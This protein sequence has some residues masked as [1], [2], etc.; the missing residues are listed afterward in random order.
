MIIPKK[1]NIMGFPHQVK[2]V[3][4]PP[5]DDKGEE[6]NGIIDIDTGII[7]LDKNLP[8]DKLGQCFLHE[9]LHA[10]DA[11]DELSEVATESFARNLYQ[12][13]KENGILR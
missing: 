2:L 13:L 11:R 3:S 4:P 8:E 1:L 12:V 7:S 6:C 10:I 5:K 9:I